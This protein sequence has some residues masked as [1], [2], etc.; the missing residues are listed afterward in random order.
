[1]L[2]R[3]PRS[4]RVGVR[5]V[6]AVPEFRG[7]IIAQIISEAGDQIARVAIAL[8]VLSQS[9]SPLLAAATFAISFVPSLLGSALLG[10]LAD[11]FSRRTLMLGADL[12]RAV[13]VG[14]IALLAVPGV[15]VWLLFGL[16]FLSEFFTPLFGSARLAS[17]PDVLGSPAYVA[18]GSGLARA[19]N[20]ANQAFGLLL[21]GVIVQLTSPRI[22]L[23]VDALS[24]VVSFAVL[25][26]T[27][28]PRP[29]AQEST[30]SLRVLLRDLGEGWTLLMHDPS[31]R[32]L[33]LLGWA[34]AATLVAPEAVG[35]AYAQD[36]GEVQGW[37]GALMAAVVIG[38]AI[39][40]LLVSRRPVREQ[41]D[42]V[43]PLAIAMS[44]PL[45]VT[46]IEPP[47][48]VLVVLW[49]LSG[50]AQAFLVP[51]MSLTSLLTPN[52][53]RGRVAGIAGAGFA[54]FTTFGYLLAGSIAAVTSPAFS[55]VV[56]AVVG[57]V[58]AGVAY[59]MWPAPSLRADVRRLEEPT[60]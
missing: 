33:V 25:A 19:L 39:G 21:G 4:K 10:P 60:G 20:L 22:A 26:A 43:L 7:I 45:L 28:H 46:G 55:V 47:I 23:F 8:L 50:A 3:G 42:L 53:Q 29:P 6:L 44:L 14:L 31:R 34:L 11:R 41:L 15:S 16:L 12:G 36:T 17:I 52:S 37:G 30:A 32:A 1:M 48:G 57:L 35:L 5:D 2:D 49:A 56:M 59:L 58:V 38:A 18:A 51:V 13:T 40:A 27:L 24:F 54:L 9:G